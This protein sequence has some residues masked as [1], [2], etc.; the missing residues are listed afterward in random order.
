MSIKENEMKLYC[1]YIFC[2][3]LVFFKINYSQNML[4]HII[5]IKSIMVWFS[6]FEFQLTICYVLEK[7]LST[8]L[9]HDF[10]LNNKILVPCTTNNLKGYRNVYRNDLVRGSP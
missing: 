5:P 8:K 2:H 6:K 1:G 4:K 9:K 10:G 3:S 7:S